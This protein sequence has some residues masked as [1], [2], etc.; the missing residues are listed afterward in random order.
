MTYWTEKDTLTEKVERP[1]GDTEV[2]EVED[3]TQ[4]EITKFRQYEQAAIKQARGEL[5]EGDIEALPD[6]EWE[7]GESDMNYLRSMI[8][9]KLVEPEIDN[10][11]D[12]PSQ[13]LN[14]LIEG[15]LSAWGL[16]MEAREAANQMPTEGNG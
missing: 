12:I 9:G 15:M 1:D 16:D 4:S 3:I 6:F 7:D 10:P 2:I 14:V 13:K 11:T 5:S 8:D